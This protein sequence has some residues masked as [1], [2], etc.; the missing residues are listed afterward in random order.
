MYAICE[1][2]GK[3]YKVEAKSSIFVDKIEG[4]EGDKVEIDKVLLVDNDGKV[5][6]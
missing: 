3:Q 6:V 2:Q 4:N 1:I 5:S